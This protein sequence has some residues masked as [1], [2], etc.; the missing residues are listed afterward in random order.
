MDADILSRRFEHIG[1]RAV[2]GDNPLFGH[3]TLDRTIRSPLAEL[4]ASFL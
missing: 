2:V 3:V 4:A 1:A